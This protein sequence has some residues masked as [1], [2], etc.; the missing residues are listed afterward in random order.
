MTGVD[1]THSLSQRSFFGAV[2]FAYMDSQGVEYEFA[3]CSEC[4]S[5]LLLPFTEC[6]HGQHGEL[7]EK[8][9]VPNGIR[10]PRKVRL[11]IKKIDPRFA[12]DSSNWR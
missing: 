1:S 8:Y 3:F 5:V 12:W 4:H 11:A 10:L 7:C 9:R 2:I 6:L